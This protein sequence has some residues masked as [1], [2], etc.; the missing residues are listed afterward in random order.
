MKLEDIWVKRTVERNGKRVPT[1][2]NP[3]P[4]EGDTTGVNLE[5]MAKLVALG[6]NLELPVGELVSQQ[7][8][9]VPGLNVGVA[10]L[11]LRSAIA[12][13][14][15]HHKGFTYAASY[16][17]AHG[18]EIPLSEAESFRKELDGLPYSPITVAGLLEVTLFLP[19][20]AMMRLEGGRPFN[21][22]AL[23]I[24]T[25]EQ[26][27]TVV[28]AG[29]S[30]ALGD[31]IHTCA[32]FHP[33]RESVLEWVGKSTEHTDLLYRASREL[34]ESQDSPSLNKLAQ[35]ASVAFVAPFENANGITYGRLPDE[36][37]E[38]DLEVIR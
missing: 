2:W 11:V 22:L 34:F 26:R 28:N 17:R 21:H 25:D 4:L 9:R 23:G 31:P 12:D 10:G 35:V 36:D 5:L 3:Q 16:L 37:W 13:E 6:L 32:R 24:N 14:A 1:F 38:K 7:L 29:I 30:E 20:L 19:F 15:R 18:V 8:K 33:I 27:H